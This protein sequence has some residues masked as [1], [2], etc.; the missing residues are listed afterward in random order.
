MTK[1]TVRFFPTGKVVELDD[2]QRIAKVAEQVGVEITLPCKGRGRCGRCGVYI[3]KT[4]EDGSEPNLIGMER[5]LACMHDIT[6]DIDIFV[7]LDE[8]GRIVA[9]E[10]QRKVYDG[11]IVPIVKAKGKTQLGLAVDLGT[12][13]IA[14]SILDLKTGFELYSTVGDNPQSFAGDDLESRRAYADEKGGDV[15]RKAAIDRIND[16][17]YTFVGDP[18][19]VKTAVISGK[20]YLMES[21]TEVCSM[22]GGPFCLGGSELGLDMAEDAPTFCVKELS[23]DVGGDLIGGILA[24][25]MD[26]AE[27][28]TLLIDIGSTVQLALGRKDSILVC[29]SESGPA[30]EGGNVTFGM[31]PSIGAIDSIQ[32]TRGR[33]GYTV[34]G[35]TKPTGICGSG[36]IDL[37]AGMYANGIIDIEGKFTKKAK[38]F[39]S[40]NGTAYAITDGIYVTEADITAVM[41]AKAAV[42]AGILT[43]LNEAK[44]TMNDI[45]RIVLS[46]SFGVFINVDNAISLGMLPDMDRDMFNF[47]GNASMTYAR[48]AMLSEDIRNRAEEVRNIIRPI[49]FREGSYDD[50]FKLVF[51]I[52]ENGSIFSKLK[53]RLL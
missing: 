5:V 30:L 2:V 4:P 38:T 50:E 8:H 12:A 22:T 29:S 14:V 53:R 10:D 17:M 37:I 1:K 27:E 20:P 3:S 7:P 15:L 16:L 21:L 33:V 42:C 51:P 13:A 39:K 32:F 31:T 19:T 35:G 48:N 9:G 24:C 49:N 41:K 18:D 26:G 40:E 46:G 11:E 47:L 25:E 23:E 44:I 52:P 34:I 43:L 28:M 6:E 36:L 45:S